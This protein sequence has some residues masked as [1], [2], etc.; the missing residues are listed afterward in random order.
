MVQRGKRAVYDPEA[1][2]YEKPSPRSGGRVQAQGA[3]ARALLADHAAGR[4]AAAPR[5]AV[6]VEIVSHR[7]LR[8]ASGVLHLIALGT[9]VLLVREGVVYKVM[10]GGQLA[11]L[12]AAAARVGI[13]R[14]YVL[15]TWATVAALATTCVA[16]SRRRG[17]RPK[18]HGETRARRRRVGLMLLVASPLLA[19]S[20][21]AIVLDDR[22]PVLYRQRRVGKE[23]VEFELLKLRTMVVGAETMGAGL[24]R[25][26]GGSENHECRPRSPA[27]VSGRAAAALECLARRH[28]PDRAA[29]DARVPGGA[30][31]AAPAP[32]ARGQAG[33]TGWAQVHGRA[34][35]PWDERIELDVWYV[36]NRSFW[37]DLKILA[38]TPVALFAGTYKGATGGWR[39]DA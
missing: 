4:H 34:R 10:L 37:L 21:A 12:A 35:L 31:H 14:Y 13:A 20:A 25:E 27:P 38:K 6:R 9:N 8:Y 22:G 29:S 19:G 23:G 32:P 18:A 24:R 5:A 1:L 17:R 28:E 3:H 16:E 7:H 15:V 36:E 11:L 39:P 26:R 30:L 2:A 33:I